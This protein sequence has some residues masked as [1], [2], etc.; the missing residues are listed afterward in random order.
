MDYCPWTQS[1]PS[2]D[3]NAATRLAEDSWRRG[4]MW[5]MT[6][7]ACRLED[8]II[9]IKPRW[10][11]GGRDEGIHSRNSA[12]K[13]ELVYSHMR[14]RKPT[15]SLVLDPSIRDGDLA[16]GIF[17]LPSKSNQS[18]AAFIVDIVPLRLWPWSHN[19]N[20][21]FPATKPRLAV[22]AAALHS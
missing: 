19:T 14:L 7:L 13:F 17:A 12:G 8:G 1:M 18:N 16:R 21:F 4:T 2:R 6:C 10:R 9:Y 22:I 5:H 20:A 11:G 3:V 15:G